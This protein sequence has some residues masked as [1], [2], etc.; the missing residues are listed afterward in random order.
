MQTT[1]LIKKI[2]KELYPTAKWSVRADKF[3]GGNSIHIR[4]EDGP[5]LGDLYDLCKMFELGYFDGMNDIY[6]YN[7]NF[8]AFGG[9]MVDRFKYVSAD[10][11]VS[12]VDNDAIYKE[13]SDEWEARTGSPINPFCCPRD[14]QHR[15]HEARENAQR[16]RHPK[17]HSKTLAKVEA[18]PSDLTTQEAIDFL[19]NQVARQKAAEERE[20][21]QKYLKLGE[22]RPKSRSI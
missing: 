10:S 20:A 1:S 3:S 11:S 8:L 13:L 18:I 5:P 19:A 21:L 22:H 17:Q 7:R 16:I 14:M 12:K 4:S 6:E 15:F 9:E 2:L